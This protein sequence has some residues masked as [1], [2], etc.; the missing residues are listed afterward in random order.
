[1][2]LFTPEEVDELERLITEWC[3]K[4]GARTMKIMV[5]V[6]RGDSLIT[7]HIY[8]RKRGRGKHGA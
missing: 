3:R 4:H 2:S 5:E 8:P 7:Y 6:H 1:M